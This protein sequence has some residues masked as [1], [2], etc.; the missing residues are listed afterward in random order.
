MVLGYGG[1]LPAFG[2]VV[3][4]GKHGQSL[5]VH[6]SSH[7]YLC[8]FFLYCDACHLL[9][10][11]GQFAF[12]KVYSNHRASGAKSNYCTPFFA[13]GLWFVSSSTTCES[14]TSARARKASCKLPDEWS[15]SHEEIVK[16]MLALLWC[17]KHQQ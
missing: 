11:L 5:F 4:K 8:V 16:Q 7:C 15:D 17:S 9:F 6:Y 3:W 13:D 2:Q 12:L 14:S 10:L 1:K